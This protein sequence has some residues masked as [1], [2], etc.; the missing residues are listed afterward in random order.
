MSPEHII[1]QENNQHQK[2]DLHKITQGIA[3]VGV[4]AAVTVGFYNS[5]ESN[6]Q[7]LSAESIAYTSN[8][9][10]V[11]EAESGGINL[12]IMGI[13]LTK[14]G[15]GYWQY[16]MNG[17]VFPSGDAIFMGSG[18]RLQQP[19]VGM[20]LTRDGKGYWLNNEKGQIISQGDA[21]NQGDLTG[22]NLTQP[23]VNMASNPNGT[24]YW[25]VASDGGIFAFGD[26]PFEGSTGN[27]K[28]NQPIVGMA[29][30]P[31]GN[32]Y[33]LTDAGQNVYKFGD[34]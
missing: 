16:R 24:G 2:L 23:V 18:I 8:N 14:D 10:R 34:A 5:H 13:V 25:E 6:Q 7:P 15:G 20:T 29:G 28:L 31:S 11:T 26:A 32:G 4:A 9:I 3:R 17:E 19:V 21:Q 27:I 30:T 1:E 33:V 12:P 22:L